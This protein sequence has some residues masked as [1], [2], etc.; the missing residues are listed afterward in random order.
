M[1]KDAIE[2]DVCRANMTHQPADHF[3]QCPASEEIDGKSLSLRG[4]IPE[5][6]S[7]HSSTRLTVTTRKHET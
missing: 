4:E 7:F 3:S 6:T 1:N 2:L 5:R